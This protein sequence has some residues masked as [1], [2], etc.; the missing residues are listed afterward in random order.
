M[1]KSI[2]SKKAVKK[3]PIDYQNYIK[4]LSRYDLIIQVG[5]SFF[6]DLYGVGQFKHAICALASG[7]PIAFLGHSV[8]PFQDKEFNFIVL[9]NKRTNSLLIFIK[10]KL[11]SG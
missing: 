7:T 11:P 5:G 6:V 9:R 1:K 3:L 8:G 10:I 4:E 2:D